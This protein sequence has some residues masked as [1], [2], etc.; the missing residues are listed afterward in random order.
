M[1]VICTYL[2]FFTMKM[3]QWFISN[4]AFQ[5]RN[6]VVKC[7]SIMASSVLI[8]DTEPWKDLKVFETVPLCNV[9][10]E[11]FLISVLNVDSFHCSGPCCGH[12]QDPFA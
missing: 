9:Q 7:F 5:R 12:K 8:S 1:R 6:L 10:Y 4:N 2:H 3:G 11:S